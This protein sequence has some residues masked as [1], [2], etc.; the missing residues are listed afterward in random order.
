[1]PRHFHF[2]LRTS[3]AV[4]FLGTVFAVLRARPCTL[5][6]VSA[7]ASASGRAL[8]WKNRDAPDI[9][10]MLRFFPGPKFA[11]IAV[12]NAADARSRSVWGGLNTAGFA[13]MNSASSDLATE[14]AAGAGNGA[15]M[16]LALGECAT[17]RDFEN[18]L[19]REKGK[20]ALAANFG[21]LDAEGNACFFETG[22]DGFQK[23]DASDPRV[24]PF[25]TI[26]RT[27]FAF[28]APDLLRG[29]GF[30]R[31]ERIS[32]LMESARAAGRIKARFFFQEAARD[33]VN[34]KL[35]SAPL[36]RELAGDPAS[37]L[38]V[39]TNHT[40]NRNSTVSVLVFEAA[41]RPDLAHL[42]TMWVILGQPVA[43]VAVPV[44][45]AAGRVP[46]V[47]AGAETAPLN[48]LARALAAY[49]YPDGRG[50]MPQY[51]DVTRLRTYGGEGVLPKILRIE[52]ELL[53]RTAAKL[54]EWEKSKPLPSE[55]AEFQETAARGVFEALTKS[56]PDIIAAGK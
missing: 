28:T 23:F 38:F 15:L 2:R 32:H 18:L 7:K 44:W 50:Q 36:T 24:A 10:N 25:G 46:S 51:L 22:R 21:V 11:F 8:M 34:E 31:F 40:I 41:P 43:G 52:N 26:V 56:F 54:A 13:I 17:V 4:L 47:T 1:M 14:G 53:K 45:P 29:G 33:L 20:Y 30:I 19:V 35:R 55:M 37:P 27:N 42:A 6:L 48:D 9:D 39:H 49:L 16:K 5:A 3:V 12:V